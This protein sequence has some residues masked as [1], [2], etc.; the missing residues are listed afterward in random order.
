METKKTTCDTCKEDL[1][2]TT[3]SIDY[4]I[5]LDCEFIPSCGGVVT[6]MSI[7]RQLK[8]AYHFCCIVCLKKFINEKF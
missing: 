5:V 6:D 8:R 7:E 1:T 2:C 4:K 3:N